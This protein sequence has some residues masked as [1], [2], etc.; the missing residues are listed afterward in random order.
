MVRYSEEIL[1]EIRNKIDIVT[2]ISNYVSLKKSGKSHKGLCPFHQEKTP[3]F[4]VD[5]QKQMFYCFG[6]GEGGNIF[7]FIMKM[8][9][10]NFPETVKLLANKAGVQLPVYK[11]QNNKET[12]EREVVYN[13]NSIAANY[14]QKNL[15]TNQGKIALNYLKKRGFN[16]EIIRKFCLGYALP[17]YEHLIYTLSSKK[18]EQRDLLKAGLVSISTKTK[19]NI[20]YFR[21]RIIFPIINLQGKIIAFGG[22]VLD[23]RLPKYINSPETIVYNK[24]KNLYGLFQAKQ[25]IRQKNQVI[26][27]EGYTDVLIAHQF[28]FDN[29]VA[30]LGTAL[31][32][33][34]IILMKRFADEV[35]IVF[36]SDPA[37]ERATLR[38]I[39]LIKKAG[40]SVKIVSLP[41][42][43]DPADILLKK[44]RIYFESLIKNA[45][46]LIDY[47]LSIMLHQY[48]PAHIAG[49][50]SIVKGLFEDLNDINSDIE[51][52]NE[53]KKIAE[54]LN[55]TEESILI[56]LKRYRKGSTKLTNIVEATHTPIES[57]NINA[58]KILIGNMLQ[59]KDVID[60]IISE[61]EVEDFTITEHREIFST[62]IN[63]YETGEKVS[64]QKVIDRI[65]HPK[66]TNLIS[67][68]MLKDVVYFD[69]DT[70][71][72][73]IKAIKIHKLQQ[74]LD[75]IKKAMHLEEKNKKNVEAKIL[76][77]YQN[78]LNRIKALT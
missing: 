10:T 55:L 3:S 11:K 61:L 15:F 41:V 34:Q 76:Q 46:P 1:E 31:T 43:S 66:I 21:N 30:S 57:T 5:G 8:E 4:M 77:E 22:R 12:K 2:L 29:S 47:K 19:K 7:T 27:M 13:L 6:C 45:L 36:D 75:I 44:G 73:S 26:I 42:E 67:R 53:I 69:L 63:L 28:G 25:S 50:V 18:V 16:E 39:D 33:Q 68:I 37:G 17:G 51:L 62:I 49:K 71:N 23:N 9:K 59:N 58:E 14:Y 56:D 54:R 40:L 72:R 35:I 20:D 60:R 48:N 74:E 32:S 64:M 38:S 70:V 65:E 78:I 52:R 24:A